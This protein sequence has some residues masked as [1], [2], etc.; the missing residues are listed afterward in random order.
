MCDSVVHARTFPCRRL[1]RPPRAMPHTRKL[2][3]LDDQPPCSSAPP[4]LLVGVHT[5]AALLR[6]SAPPTRERTFPRSLGL[7]GFGRDAAAS[8]LRRSLHPR[9]PTLDIVVDAIVRVVPCLHKSVSTLDEIQVERLETSLK[10]RAQG[11]EIEDA[12]SHTNV[13]TLF[14]S[15]DDLRAKLVSQLR[16]VLRR[17]K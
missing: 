5:P 13:N 4:S 11:Y 17:M 15:H 10:S 16:E 2:L 1:P 6:L 8:A 9:Q 3:S 7:A 14:E 12:R